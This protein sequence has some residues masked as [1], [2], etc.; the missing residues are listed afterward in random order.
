ME[1]KVKKEFTVLSPT[2]ILGYGFPEES[3]YR[4]LEASPDLIAVDGGSTDPGPYYLGAGKSFTDRTGVKRDLRYMITEGVK[5][6]IPVVVGTAGGS[7]A[8]PHLQ[9]C[10]QIVEEI[11]REQDLSFKLGLIHSDI[12]RE[13]V[14][15][16]LKAGK[17]TPLEYV[18]ELT[19]EAL[20]ET[21]NIVAQIGVEPMIRALEEGCQVILSGRAYDPACFSALPIMKGYDPGLAT[22]MGKILECAAIAAS[23]GSG[24]DCVLGI[25]EEDSFRLETLS[26]ERR[27]TAE[28]TAAHTLYEKSDPYHLHGPGGILNLE[29][30]R[31]EEIPSGV[32]VRGSRFEPSGSY[33]VKLEGARLIGYR[34]ISIAGTRDR[35]LINQIESVADLVKKR[36]EDLLKKENLQGD[37]SFHLYGKNGVMGDLEPEKNSVGKELAIVIEAIAPEQEM[38]DTIC[39]MTRSTFL[40]YGYDGRISTAGNLAFPF[41]PSD[42][43]A[44]EVYTFSLYHIMEVNDQELFKVEVCEL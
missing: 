31:F 24:S 44:G 38:A 41:S 11:A 17:I 1:N 23:P 8:A 26:P 2:A 13:V 10:R 7:G 35:I 36:V 32:R 33:T 19:E 12:D 20:D 30:C 18:P 14:R 4:G 43:R 22:H 28:S 15:T 39:S 21:D 37:V 29:S 3:F 34:T 9:W 16:A 27:F 6:G 42:I 25:L 5:R 40:H